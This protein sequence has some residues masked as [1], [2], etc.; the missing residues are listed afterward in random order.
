MQKKQLI[1]YLFVGLGASNCLLILELEKKRLLDGKKIIIL[2]PHQKNKKDKTYCFWSTSDNVE[3]IIPLDF[4]DKEWDRVIINRKVQSLNPLKYYHVSSLTLY[5]KALKIIK[6]HNVKILKHTLEKNQSSNRIITDNIVYEPKYS[7]DSRP[8]LIKKLQKNQFYINQSFVGWQI[9]TNEEVF[10]PQSFTMMDFEIPQDNSTQFVYVLP[11]DSKHA[12]VEVTRFGEDIM[13][14]DEGEKL[15]NNY[16]KNYKNYQVLDIE[17]GCIP[18]TNADISTEICSNIRNMGAR[19]GHIKPSTGYAFKSMSMDATTIVNQIA[20]E[21][22]TIV[23]SNV[24]IRDNRFA[25]YDSLLLRI[26]SEKSHLGKPIFKRLFQ[27]IKAPEI[28]YFLDEESSL[29]NELKI[30][31]SLQW[32]PF[33]VAALKVLWNINNQIF[34]SFLPLLLSIL[35]LAFQS[36]NMTYLTDV[37]LVTG[38]LLIGIPHGAIDHLIETN[39]F[40]QSV[41]LKFIALYLAQGAVIVLLW[42]MN[43]LLALLIFIGYSIFHFAQADFTEWKL[44]SKIS[45]IWGILFFCGILLSHPIELNEILNQLSI[46]ELPKIQGNI[47]SSLWQDIAFGCLGLGIIMGFIQR[48]TAMIATSLFLLLT[49]Q[50]TLIHAFG[51]YFI[52]NHSLLGWNHLRNHFQVNSL[53]LWKKASLFSFGSYALFLFLYWYFGNDFGNYI[54]TFFVFLSAISFPHVLRMNNFYNYYKN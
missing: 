39:H 4:I 27:R 22:E 38:L 26:L 19:A 42:Y 41:S 6:N 46:S 13:S 34:K 37:F 33:I 16:L 8:P 36:L 10:D 9:Q 11:F 15:L 44:N 2:E 20:L 47:F 17:K 23:P 21:N 53:Q 43:P 12:L 54:G 51:T 40:N 14:I 29:S 5:E 52:Y 35:F 25:F 45:W 7:F 30:F 49:T 24:Q 1:D 32:K 50:L 31:Y 28:L 18:M 48:S 3:K